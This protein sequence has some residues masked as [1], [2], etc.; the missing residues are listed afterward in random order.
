MPLSE[1]TCDEINGDSESARNFTA[2]PLSKGQLQYL[3]KLAVLQQKLHDRLIYGNI[4]LELQQMSVKFSGEFKKNNNS[5][6]VALNMNP[7]SK[8]GFDCIDQNYKIS[9]KID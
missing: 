9:T 7:C 6:L 3:G 2:R 1:L 8:T 4:N 5:A